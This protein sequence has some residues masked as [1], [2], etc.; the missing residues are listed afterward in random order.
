MS[1]QENGLN[2]EY[3]VFHAHGHHFTVKFMWRSGQTNILRA[4]DAMMEQ[5]GVDRNCMSYISE[6][7]PSGDSVQVFDAS[8][9]NW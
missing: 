4:Q 5:Y 3:W 9:R 2:V 6:S 7:A 8:Y 1:H